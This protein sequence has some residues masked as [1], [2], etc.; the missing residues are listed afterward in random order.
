MVVQVLCDRSDKLRHAAETASTDTLVGQFA[1]PPLDQVQPGTRRRD[2]MQVEPRVPP[3]PGCHA[4][5]LVGPIVVYNQMQIEF[6]PRRCVDLLEEPDEFLVSMPRHAVA[7]DFPI[8][9]A[10]GREQ[11]GRAVAFVV[12]RHGATA[13]PLQ[14]KA[15]LGAVEG[16]DL[17]LLVDAQD[18]GLVRGIEVEPDDIVELLD[19]LLVPA[20]LEGPDEMGLETMLLP[21]TPNRRL[22]EAL[23]LGHGPRTPVG[24]GRRCRVQRGLDDGPDFAFGDAWDTTS[25][26]GVFFQ[27]RHSKRQKP[28]SPKLHRGP[29]NF[30]LPG[31]VLIE[32]AIRG[33]LNNPSTLH[34]S[35]WDTPAMRP[36]GHDRALLE[37]Q[38]D[39]SCGS[40]A[41]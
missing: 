41:P 21:D 32:D 35:E 2:E 40:H 9:H 6:G 13:A 26:R 10:Q 3:K 27:A 24:G 33:H 31:D 14:R 36:S 1:E 29:G 39:R 12:V 5:V 22:A 19:K 4:R 38:K 23:G 16:L 20:E 25:T 28:L 7:D 8:E 17:A 30:Q 11:G 18:Q 34:Q 37:R 15:W